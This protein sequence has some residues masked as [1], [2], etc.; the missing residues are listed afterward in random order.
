MYVMPAK[1]GIHDFT[2]YGVLIVLHLYKKNHKKISSWMPAFAGMT[3]N[4]IGEHQ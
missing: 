1:A 4:V 2:Y 3:A